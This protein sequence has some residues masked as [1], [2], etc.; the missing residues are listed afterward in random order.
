MYL[1]NNANAHSKKSIYREFIYIDDE[2]IEVDASKLSLTAH[3]ASDMND[4]MQDVNDVKSIESDLLEN[5]HVKNKFISDLLRVTVKIK[6]VQKKRDVLGDS[7]IEKSI[8]LKNAADRLEKQLEFTKEVIKK[9][10]KI[11]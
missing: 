7:D 5:E 4:L 2:K 3:A 9:L 1:Q 10:D 8:M 6:L 11:D